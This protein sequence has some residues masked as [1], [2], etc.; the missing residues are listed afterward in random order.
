[1]KCRW[2]LLALGAALYARAGGDGVAAQGGAQASATLQNPGTPWS[3]TRVYACG[4]FEFVTRT[5]PGELALWLPR[6][7]LVLSQVRSASGAKY[8]EG[9]VVFWSKGAEAL[10]QV[11]DREYLGC[12]QQPE[13]APWA[14]ARRRGVSFRAV[15]N[16]PGWMLEILPGRQLVLVGDDGQLRLA[17]P[18]P[19]A[20]EQGE[21]RHYRALTEAG[22]L[23]VEI[24]QGACF[25]TVSGEA[26]PAVVTVSV[27]GRL[28]QGC[29]REL[30]PLV[31]P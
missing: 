22:E 24:L 10:L 31:N 1:M 29:G 8:Q 21:S 30:T 9:D 4:D 11:G 5:G 17:T 3:R 16:E 18:D 13:R 25:D 2:L 12:R 23:Q 7:Y 28:L 19:G 27:N 20:Q 26:F 15:G 14:D 6:R